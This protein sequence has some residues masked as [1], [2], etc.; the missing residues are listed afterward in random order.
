M[1]V[2][3][4]KTRSGHARGRPLS[5]PHACIPHLPPTTHRRRL[6]TASRRRGLNTQTGGGGIEVRKL[7]EWERAIADKRAKN[8]ESHFP[9][10]L[11]AAGSFRIGGSVIGWGREKVVLIKA[12]VARCASRGRAR[13]PALN[14]T[15]ENKWIMRKLALPVLIRRWH[16]L[17]GRGRRIESAARNTS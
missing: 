16:Q 15:R 12:R 2:T 1:Q 5:R 11:F 8:N 6:I 4:H 10:A 7:A 9:G 17:T 3:V 14:P 13:L